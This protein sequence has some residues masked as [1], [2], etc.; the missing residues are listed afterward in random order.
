MGSD[1]SHYNVSIIVRDKV[2]RQFR[3]TT[4]FAKRKE[5]RSGIEPRLFCLPAYNALPLGQTDSHNSKCAM[6]LSLC[7][8]FCAA[9]F[10]GN[11]LGL[12][13]NTLLTDTS[14]NIKASYA[15]C[16]YVGSFLACV[17]KQQY[18]VLHCIVMCRLP[19]AVSKR[20]DN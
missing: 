18:M 3:Q 5:S 17:T 10:Y 15:T 14:K 12:C 13:Q 2:T 19:W 16:S 20:I 11:C 7:S 9:Y 4:A 8:R 1:E 6:A